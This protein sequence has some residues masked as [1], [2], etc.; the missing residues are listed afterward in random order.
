M[1]SKETLPVGFHEQREPDFSSEIE[2]VDRLPY[3]TAEQ[4]VDRLEAKIDRLERLQADIDQL[5]RLRVEAER[6]WIRRLQAAER[7]RVRLARQEAKRREV[8]R[9]A[10]AE[11]RA[12]EEQAARSTREENARRRRAVATPP[13]RANTPPQVPV[14]SEESQHGILNRQ[15]QELVLRHGQRRGLDTGQ[16]VG[17]QERLRGQQ[18]APIQANNPGPSC[19]VIILYFCAVYILLILYN[20][21]WKLIFEL[22]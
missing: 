19:L 17:D 20:L 1:S 11:R 12:R 14:V 15:T 9:H 16:V 18:V 13:D 6:D 7:D 5:R 4:D 8:E 21:H 22:W 3:P 10:R 2:P